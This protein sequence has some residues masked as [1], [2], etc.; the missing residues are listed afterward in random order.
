MSAN[1]CKHQADFRKYQAAANVFES[2]S[3]PRGSS[4]GDPATGIQLM[5]HLT[6]YAAQPAAAASSARRRSRRLSKATD[7]SP[8]SRPAHTAHSSR[9]NYRFHPSTCPAP[10][11]TCPAPAMPEVDRFCSWC[12]EAGAEG[13]RWGQRPAEAYTWQACSLD[14]RLHQ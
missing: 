9:S 3:Q 11:M 6:A 8:T 10:A 13:G 7:P 1:F 12:A 2:A 14:L 5:E 4:H